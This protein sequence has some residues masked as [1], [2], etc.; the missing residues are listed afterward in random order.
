VFKVVF[1][2]DSGVGKSSFIHRFCSNQFRPKFQA[3]IGVDFQVKNIRVDGHVIA[4]QLWDTAGQ[5][6]FRSI[7]K[8]YFRKA[9]GVLVMYDVTSEMTFRSV[10]NWMASV[11]E[12]TDDDTVIVLIANKMDLVDDVTPQVVTDKDGRRL[13]DE[14][15]ALFFEASAKSAL[16]VCEAMEAMSRLLSEREDRGMEKAL[17]LTDNFDWK[18]GCCK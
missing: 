8:Q 5:E 13:A 17:Q 9:D 10:R 15:G 1:V 18:R 16:N 4:L 2:G 7:T 6:R 12:G 11:K 3:T 14:F